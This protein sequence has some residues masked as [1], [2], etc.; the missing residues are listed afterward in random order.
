MKKTKEWTE[1]NTK[2]K[3]VLILITSPYPSRNSCQGNCV[4]GMHVYTT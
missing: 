2:I 1:M 3:Y 4:E